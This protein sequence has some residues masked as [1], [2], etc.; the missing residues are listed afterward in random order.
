V[1][2]IVKRTIETPAP[3]VQKLR[4]AMEVKGAKKKAPTKKDGAD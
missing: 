4:I 2:A 3:L 1:A